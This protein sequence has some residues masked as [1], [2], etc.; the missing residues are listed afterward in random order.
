MVK[1]IF[2]F[3]LYLLFAFLLIFISCKEPKNIQHVQQ[4]IIKQIDSTS[5][6]DSLAEIKKPELVIHY[7]FMK[8]E[9][10]K[11]IDSLT[12]TY[13]DEVRKLILALNR[14]D[15]RNLHDDDSLIV[16]ATVYSDLLPYSPFPAKLD[17]AKSI[18]KLLIFSYPI[19]AFAAYEKGEL[20]RW[21]PTSMGKQSTPTPTGLF[22][23]NWKARQTNSTDDSAWVLPWYFNIIN[24][25][26]ISIHQYALP[27]Y[28]ASHACARLLDD[29]AK[30]IYYWADQWI[31]TDD[32]ED[33]VAYGTPVI[34]FGKY[35]FGNKTPLWKN[36]VENP[37]ATTVDSIEVNELIKN[38]L[39]DIQEKAAVRDS[40]LKARGE[41]PGASLN[42]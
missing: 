39:P 28:P 24:K 15:V 37:N 33:V 8:I 34:I 23:T 13:G 3:S 20:V 10:R 41:I 4:P 29:D 1:I 11:T 26:G 12:N 27:G 7:T 5:I 35:E 2:R 6:K 31:V 40:V 21:G 22:Y 19:Q 17:S 16:P 32:G 42:I 25:R 9:G 38:Y 18:N 30:W 14:L 36:L